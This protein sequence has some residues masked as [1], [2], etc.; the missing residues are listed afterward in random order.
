MNE[1]IKVVLATYSDSFRLNEGK[2]LV[3]S[4]GTTII[5]YSRIVKIF[6]QK[7]LKHSTYGLGAGKAEENLK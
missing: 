4:S 1:S 7:C 6:T 2:S 3:E 5:H